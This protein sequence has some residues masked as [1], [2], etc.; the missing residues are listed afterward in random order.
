LGEKGKI[1]FLEFFV[2]EFL[3]AEK[4]VAAGSVMM[5]GLRE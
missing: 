2:E 5:I 4:A 3:H 1:G